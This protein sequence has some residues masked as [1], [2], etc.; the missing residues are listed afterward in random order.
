MRTVIRGKGF[1]AVRAHQ[2]VIGHFD[3]EAV[4]RVRGRHA[5]VAAAAAPQELVALLREQIARSVPI[6]SEERRRVDILDVEESEVDHRLVRGKDAGIHPLLAG[7]AHELELLGHLDAER[8]REEEAHGAPVAQRR[9]HLVG[10]RGLSVGYVGDL[11]IRVPGVLVLAA[12]RRAV[13]DEQLVVERIRR[14]ER[15]RDR[16]IRLPRNHDRT[17]ERRRCEHRR[18]QQSHHR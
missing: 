3:H 15:E 16:R 18:T 17:C 8:L 13:R 11:H 2:Q 14:P 4:F 12:I 1:H 5:Q 9:R 10:E 7:G 6:L